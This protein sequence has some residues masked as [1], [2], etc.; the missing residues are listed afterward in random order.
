MPVSR[1]SDRPAACLPPCLCRTL[2]AGSL[3]LLAP[4]LLPALVPSLVSTPYVSGVAYATQAAS[5]QAAAKPPADQ[6]ASAAPPATKPPAAKTAPSKPA[7]AKTASAKTASA[8]TAPAKTASTG[9]APAKPAATRTP[10][11]TKTAGAAATIAAGAASAGVP[12]DWEQRE[13]VQA[14]V[15]AMVGRHGFDEAKLFAL[16][17]R[18][19]SSPA[20][21]KLMAPAPP[22]FKRSWIVYRDRF[23]EP[24]RIREGLRFW[25]A[26]AV[27]VSRAAERWGVPEEILVSIIGVET[28]YGRHTGDF[29][30]MDALTTLAFDYPRREAFFREELE[31]YLLLAREAGFDPLDWRGSFAGAV[32]LPQFMPGSIRRHAVDFDGDGRIDLRSSPTDAIGSVASFLANHGWRAGEPTHFAVSIED[33]ARARPAI[34]AGIPPSLTPPALAEMGVTSPEAIPA[35]TRLALIDLPNGD[36]TT[37]HVLGAHNFWVITRYNRSYFYAMAVIELGRA[38]REAAEREPAR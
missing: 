1:S 21:I 3:L 38:L 23:V 29:R 7:P 37:H 12:A 9:T 22:G 18:T 31:Q 20:A 2:A 28:L 33:A 32:G 8:K 13:S 10:S 5:K 36:D 30:V 25:R 15:H 6:A 35:D 11:P 17:G 19:R 4:A 24:V 16:F 34:D 14:F 26:N 27:A